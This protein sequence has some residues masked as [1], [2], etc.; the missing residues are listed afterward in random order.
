[1]FNELK[2]PPWS[3]E[4]DSALHAIMLVTGTIRAAT[5]NSLWRVTIRRAP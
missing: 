4:L 2:S 5:S 3:T 1:M